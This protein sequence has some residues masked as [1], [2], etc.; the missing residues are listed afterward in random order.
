[1]QQGHPLAGARANRWLTVCF[2]LATAAYATAAVIAMAIL[3]PRVPYA[4][5]WRHYARLLGT[6][7]PGSVLK[8]ENGHPEVV[9]NLVRLTDLLWLRGD[10]RWQIAVGIALSLATFG[11]GL[12]AVLRAGVPPLARSAAACVLSLGIFWLGNA[13]ALAH[14]N[15]SLHVYSVL[16][17]TFAALV[18]VLRQDDRHAASSRRVVAAAAL[19]FFASFNFGSGLASF[20][21]LFAVL[22]MQRARLR[23]LM[24]A[25][26]GLA[27]T[28]VCYHLLDGSGGV[29]I[30]LQPIS[31]AVLALRWIASPLIYLVWPLVDPVAAAALPGPLG[32]LAGAAA[33][34]WTEVF[35]EVRISVFPHVFFG[36]AFFVAT[37]LATL[38]A[39]AKPEAGDSIHR[40][41]LAL[42]WFGLGV[43]AM[44]AVSRSAY[45]VEYPA[46]VYAPRYLPWPSLAWAGLLMAWAGRASAKRP[47]YA[48]AL[49][50]S[51][52]ALAAEGGMSLV[53]LHQ[54]EVAEDVALA[55]V[56]G[57]WPG[58]NA[59]GEVNAADTRDGAYVLRREATGPFAW[60]EAE[61]VGRSVPAGAGE[62]VGASLVVTRQ[63]GVSDEAALHVEANGVGAACRQRLLVVDRGRV[64]GL[65]RPL[66]GGRWRG[67]ARAEVG[68]PLQ[69]FEL[70]CS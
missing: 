68:A 31:D 19:C 57:V 30:R 28:L 26:A 16:L 50:V 40:F 36:G 39:R 9:A 17:C 47:A 32:T 11:V 13:R 43:A 35:G 2:A 59:I 61:W 49:A 60:P 65:L 63:E 54:R 55:A 45:F 29:P 3:S 69:L 42:A 33:R 27:L 48:V 4:D 12:A 62:R 44:V 6:P 20:I 18:L 56:V 5:A 21:A 8:A 38:R 41:G 67:V 15:E 22:F 37:L 10:E 46:Q 66:G 7:F 23:Q 1:M 25:G 52:F 53:M 14:D 58:E 24:I 51:I 64:V 34:H 70:A